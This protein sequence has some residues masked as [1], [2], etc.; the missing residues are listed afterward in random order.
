[1]HH[2]SCTLIRFVASGMHTQTPESN[3]TRQYQKTAADV[4]VLDL[5]EGF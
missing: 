5:Y 2:Q 4:D 1:M 3:T